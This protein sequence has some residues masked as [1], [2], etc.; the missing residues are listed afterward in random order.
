MCS[1]RNQRCVLINLLFFR[2][3][4]SELSQKSKQMILYLLIDWKIL[5][6]LIFRRIITKDSHHPIP[7]FVRE[8][9]RQQNKHTLVMVH[10]LSFRFT[11]IIRLSCS[12]LFAT[13]K[14][15]V[16]F[17]LLFIQIASNENVYNVHSRKQMNARWIR[18]SEKIS[19]V[20]DSY[21]SIFYEEPFVRLFHGQTLR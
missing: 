17:Q 12:F 7:L 20:T 9:R 11:L 13:G 10:C 19:F 18:V 21:S 15:N 1:E 16:S 5:S 3:C 8:N 4:S 14:K 2:S 6:V